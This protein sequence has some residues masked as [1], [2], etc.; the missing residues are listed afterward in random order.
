MS[1]AFTCR[2]YTSRG[3]GELNLEA[4][5][6]VWLPPPSIICIF[7]I[8]LLTPS[9]R[10]PHPSINFPLIPPP[11]LNSAT[12]LTSTGTWRGWEERQGWFLQLTL[13]SL[14]GEI[15]R[16]L[17]GKVIHTLSNLS[18][19][20]NGAL[21]EIP[22]PLRRQPSQPSPSG[23]HRSPPGSR[24]LSPVGGE[25]SSLARGRQILNSLSPRD[26]EAQELFV[27]REF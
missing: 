3:P 8:Q 1:R 5:Q 17:I 14:P 13:T 16:H 18:S 4:G 2:S 20:N 27:W 15:Q 24:H 23:S 25:T 19:P 9:K 6:L 7:L 26:A 12:E 22:S 11:R 10:L 21:P